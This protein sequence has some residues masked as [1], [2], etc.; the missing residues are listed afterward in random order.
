MPTSGSSNFGQRMPGVSKSSKPPSTFTHCLPRVTPGLF[1][2][3]APFRPAIWLINVD[4]PTFGMPTTM[5]LSGRPTCP[6]S[7]YR[8]SFSASS[9]RT[10]GANVLMPFRDLQSVR[11]T[12]MPL[13]LK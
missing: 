11:M 8:W 13:P 1:S 3:F 9:C 12:A 5:S 10:A 7:A 2:A 6:F 4:F